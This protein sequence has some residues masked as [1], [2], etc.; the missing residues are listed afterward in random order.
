MGMTENVKGLSLRLL[1]RFDKHILLL[2]YND[3]RGSGPNFDRAGGPTVF[4]GLY[5]VA[6]LGIVKIALAVLYCESPALGDMITNMTSVLRERSSIWN[7]LFLR[8]R[9]NKNIWEV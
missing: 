9:A 1:D 3:D 7:S 6:F 4:I 8:Y 5:K 2:R